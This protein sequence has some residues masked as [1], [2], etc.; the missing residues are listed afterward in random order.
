MTDA[1]LLRLEGVVKLFGE[2]QALC[3]IDLTVESGQVVSIIGPSGCGKSTLLRCI[4]FL[5][6]PDAGQVLLDGEPLGFRIV[7]GRR[8]RDSQANINRM[9]SRIG[10]VFQQFNVWP[11]LSVLEN[12]VM[13]QVCVARRARS[14]AERVARE[15]LARVGLADKFNAYPAE[16]SGGQLQRVAIA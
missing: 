9:R 7:N 6:A 2:M 15:H 5:E 13:P 10:M 16:L 12:V 1:P 3:G 14:D 8:R 4:N 11:H